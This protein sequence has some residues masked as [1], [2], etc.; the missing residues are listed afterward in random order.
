MVSVEKLKIR[1]KRKR[2]ASVP[3]HWVWILIFNVENELHNRERK[4]KRCS[5]CDPWWRQFVVAAAAVGES[6]FWVLILGE[7]KGEF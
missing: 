5:G 2:K 6:E 1:E 3:R 7:G 4:T